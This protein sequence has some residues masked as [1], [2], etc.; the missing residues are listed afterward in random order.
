MIRYSPLD[1]SLLFWIDNLVAMAITVI[2]VLFEIPFVWTCFMSLKG[3]VARQLQIQVQDQTFDWVCYESIFKKNA[4]VCHSH[5]GCKHYWIRNLIIN[6]LA[7]IWTC[8]DLDPGAEFTAAAETCTQKGGPAADW[9]LATWSFE[10]KHMPRLKS[11]H[12]QVRH[13][14]QATFALRF[15]TFWNFSRNEKVRW[16]TAAVKYT[17]ALGSTEM[18][19]MRN[20]MYSEHYVCMSTIYNI[21]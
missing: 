20:Y 8:S 11:L 5:L 16:K 7:K 3:A 17:R 19:P 6:S 15:Q 9:G 21:Q 2:C 14:L 1:S 10:M 4:S 18:Y 12:P 13:R